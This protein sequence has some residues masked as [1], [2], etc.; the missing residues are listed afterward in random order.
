MPED[1]Q[2]NHGYGNLQVM[3]TDNRGFDIKMYN[4]NQ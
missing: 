3:L 2:T 1:R 4:N